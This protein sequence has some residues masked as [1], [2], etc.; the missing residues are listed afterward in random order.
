MS[1]DWTALL[2]NPL[3]NSLG[4]AATL[5]TTPVTVIDE[6]RGVGLSGNAV[7]ET[8]KPAARI[9]ATELADNNIDASSLKDNSL[10]F[11]GKTWRI[12]SHEP[13]PSKGGEADGQIRLFLLDEG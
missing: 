6:T 13:L 5:G 9:R 12:K 10:T 1:I 7:I 3:Y 4:V 2:Y 8:V 11:N